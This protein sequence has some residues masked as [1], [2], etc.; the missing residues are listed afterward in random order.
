[1]IWVI[2]LKDLIMYY[3]SRGEAIVCPQGDRHTRNHHTTGIRSRYT[4][5]GTSGLRRKTRFACLWPPAIS[6]AF[7]ACPSV[8]R[9]ESLTSFTPFCG[10]NWTLWLMG[11]LHPCSAPLWFRFTK[12]LVSGNFLRLQ[13]S[14]LALRAR[15]SVSGTESLTK[16]KSGPNRPKSL[17]KT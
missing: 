3:S 1:M 6:R 5:R 17:T 2:Q 13:G 9:T 4:L 12:P 14:L 7:G 8:S 15:P 10:K 16:T 11:A